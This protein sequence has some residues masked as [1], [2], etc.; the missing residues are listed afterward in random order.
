M[1][2]PVPRPDIG[3]PT[4]RPQSIE[5]VR[6]GSRRSTGVATALIEGGEATVQGK[7]NG[8]LRGDGRPPQTMPV[9]G[10]TI[11]TFDLDLSL[12]A[13]QVLYYL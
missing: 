5:P 12:Y 1:S 2:D 6:E 10:D 4:V 11:G 8:I 13:T 3:P 9:V 7:D